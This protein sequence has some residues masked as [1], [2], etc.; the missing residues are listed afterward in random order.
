[1]YKSSRRKDDEKKYRTGKISGK[2]KIKM[3]T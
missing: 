1:M 3:F 2:D